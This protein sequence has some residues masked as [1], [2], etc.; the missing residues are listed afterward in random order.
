[1]LLLLLSVVVVVVV[2]GWVYGSMPWPDEQG[3]WVAGRTCALRFD[4]R[5]RSE[6]SE[7][8]LFFLFQSSIFSTELQFTEMGHKNTRVLFSSVGNRDDQRG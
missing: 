5:Y 1:M 7:P 3:R 2:G 6:S 8:A 4:H